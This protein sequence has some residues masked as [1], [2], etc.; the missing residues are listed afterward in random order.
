M[1]LRSI[2]IDSGLKAKKVADDL[3]ISRVQLY[4]LENGINKL[5]DDK[6]VKLSEIYNISKSEI[7]SSIKEE[8]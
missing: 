2:R 1:S 7:L 4:N 5:T 3:G 6:I 8:T